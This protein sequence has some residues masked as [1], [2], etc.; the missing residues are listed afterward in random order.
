MYD[1]STDLNNMTK[2]L[3]YPPKRKRLNC[4]SN[5]NSM[6]YKILIITKKT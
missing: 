2:L 1:L 6:D 4:L 3:A 5:T